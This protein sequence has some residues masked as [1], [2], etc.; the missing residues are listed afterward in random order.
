MWKNA[1]F[2]KLLAGVCKAVV[3]KAAVKKTK[4]NKK[5]TSIEREGGRKIGRE[6]LKQDANNNIQVFFEFLF[7]IFY[8]FQFFFSKLISLSRLI[9]YYWFS[10]F[11]LTQEASPTPPQ[12][13]PKQPS[14]GTKRLSTPHIH[15]RWLSANRASMGCPCRL[16]AARPG[17]HS[18][19]EH[20]ST[21]PGTGPSTCHC[22]LGRGW[23]DGTQGVRC[24]GSS[25]W[26][27][28]L[29]TGRGRK[30]ARAG[31]AGRSTW[32]SR[33]SKPLPLHFLSFKKNIYLFG[34][35]G[36]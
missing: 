12:P 28:L 4:Q 31:R 29:P 3:T 22:W 20:R 15:T 16:Q 13:D 33:P 19:S 25:H 34:C 14:H 30:R 26:A 32:I 7:Q 1:P 23:G 9:R 27:V 2:G 17:S 6:R 35:T 21:A 8:G 11:H 24:L 5:K 36:S 10:A 18:S